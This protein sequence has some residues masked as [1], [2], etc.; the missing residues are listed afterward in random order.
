V[1]QTL[2][3]LAPILC[4]SAGAFILLGV[5]AWTRQVTVRSNRAGFWLALLTIAGAAISMHAP[6]GSDGFVARQMMVWDGLS[7]FFSWIVLLT[8]FFVVLLSQHFAEFAGLRMNSYYALLCLAIAGLQFLVSANDFIMIFLGIELFGVPSFILAGYLR[9]SQ[10]SSEAALKLFLIGA[11]SSAMLVYGI[12]LIY[13]ITGST[14]LSQLH[15]KVSL[16]R[17]LAPLG[18]MGIFFVIVSFGFKIALVPF[19]MWVPDV[20]EGAPKPVAALLSVAP[21]I[22]GAAIA[23]RVFDLVLPQADLGFLTILA[24][25]AAV[26]MTVANAIGLW[27]TNVVRLLAYSSIAHMGYLLLGLVGAGDLGIASTYLYGWVYLFMNLGAFAIVIIVSRSLGSDELSAYAGLARRSPYLAALLTLF[28]ISLA[29]LPPL[30]GFVAKFYVFL[31]AFRSGWTWLVALGALNSV[32]SVA[33][34]FKIVHW[35]YL[36]TAPDQR[37]ITLAASERFTLAAT[38]FFTLFLGLAPQ[39]FVTTAQ[40]FSLVAKP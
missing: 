30:A 37:P 5:D 24:A 40:A 17:S 3:I 14:S 21:K 15:D 29:G 32:I 20:F 1:S 27:Q 33:Y 39:F 18:V 11:F 23:L 10:R 9:Q 25:L 28:L 4:L 31:A 16:L 8:A 13:G 36:R 38:S 19:H 7:Y 22:A 34:Y 26:T 35:M 12:A 2:R 6:L